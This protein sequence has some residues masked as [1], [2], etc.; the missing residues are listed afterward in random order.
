MISGPRA[1]AVTGHETQR[2]AIRAWMA[3]AALLMMLGMWAIVAPVRAWPQVWGPSSYP[4]ASMAKRQARLQ[5][6]IDDCS[7]WATTV[8]GFNPGSNKLPPS[9]NEPKPPSESAR[10]HYNRW[11]GSCLG[12]RESPAN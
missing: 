7:R 12:Q 1:L 5:T 8:T 10:G 2:V 11:M 4:A 9:W 6:D 3:A